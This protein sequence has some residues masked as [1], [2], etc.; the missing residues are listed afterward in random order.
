MSTWIDRKNTPDGPRYREWESIV[1][2]YTTPELTREGMIQYLN[3]PDSEKR[4]SRVDAHGT[5]LIYDKRNPDDDWQTEQCKAKGCGAFHHAFLLSGDQC[6]ECGEPQEY[7]GH[8]PPCIVEKRPYDP[9][10]AANA[11]DAVRKALTGS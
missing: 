7:K 2:Q 4:L 11:L 8:A 5:S 9:T 6:S 1:D 10:I 3:S